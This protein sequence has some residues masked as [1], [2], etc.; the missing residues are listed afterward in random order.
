MYPPRHPGIRQ[1]KFQIFCDI[2]HI[3]IRIGYN[4]NVET[5][6]MFSL[7]VNFHRIKFIALNYNLRVLI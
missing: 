1:K 3:F 6:I 2:N 7:I 5:L 4:Y